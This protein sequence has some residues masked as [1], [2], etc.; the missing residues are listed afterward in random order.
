MSKWPEL[1]RMAPSFMASK[2]SDRSTS[3]SPVTVMKMSPSRAASIIGST[4]NPSMTAS[5]ARSGSTSVTTTWAPMPR[6]RLDD[7][8]AAVAVA[9]DDDDLAGQQHVGGPDDAVEGRLAGAVAVVEHV[10]GVGVVHGDD[11]ELQGPVGLHGPQADDAGG[12][13]LGAGQDLAH[14]VGALPVQAGHQ[15]AA[16]VHGHLRVGVED[17]VDVAEVGLGVLALDGVDGDALVQGQRGGHVVLG[18]QRVRGAGDDGGAARL[19]RAEQVGG[20]GG[21]V[22]ARRRWRRRRADAPWRSARGCW[23]A[24]ACGC[25]P[26]RC[27][28]GRAPASAGVRDVVLHTGQCHCQIPSGVPS[29]ADVARARLIPPGPGSVRGRPPPGGPGGWR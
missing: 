24:P 16:V 15:V 28:G 1:A 3:R 12:G 8:L 7:A 20:L 2:C 10:L 26:R 27:A 19:E 17:G 4:R 13:L 9:G 25:R 23:P 22:Q 29:P 14:L 6:A 21:D 11:R 5:S 18:G